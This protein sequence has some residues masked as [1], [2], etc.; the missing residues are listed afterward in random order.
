MNARRR[1]RVPDVRKALLALMIVGGTGSGALAQTLQ[2]QIN[3]VYQAQQQ[4]EAR[5]RAAYEAQQAEMRRERQAA[6]AAEN[7]RTAAAVAAQ[8][9]REAAALADKQRNQGYE[10]QLRE[11]NIERQK[12][13]LEAE[14]ARVARENDYINADLAH[15]SAETDVVKSEAERTRSEADANRNVSSGVKNY[16]DQSGLAEVRKSTAPNEVTPS[17]GNKTAARG[18]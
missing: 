17:E 6:I 11:L 16:L 5:Q 9:Q 12:T 2:D 1:R 8:K 3:S 13:S 10:D 14:K 18:Q 7:A 15:R 4:E